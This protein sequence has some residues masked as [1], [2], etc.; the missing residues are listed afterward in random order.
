V[1]LLTAGDQMPAEVIGRVKPGGKYRIRLDSKTVVEVWRDRLRPRTP[2]AWEDGRR[3]GCRRTHYELLVEG[4][5]DSFPLS[6]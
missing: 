4:A 6:S 2:D 5:F 1:L 3:A